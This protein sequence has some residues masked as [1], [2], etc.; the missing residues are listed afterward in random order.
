MIVEEEQVKPFDPSLFLGVP[1]IFVTMKNQGLVWPDRGG[2]P[3][4]KAP[5]DPRS[6]VRC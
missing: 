2:N 5:I 6:R 3:K 1:I 4:S